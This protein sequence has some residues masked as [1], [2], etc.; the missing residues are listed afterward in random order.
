[1]AAVGGMRKIKSSSGNKLQIPR[2]EVRR[3]SSLQ[4]VH[5]PG[6]PIDENKLSE[7]SAISASSSFFSL[8]SADNSA[9]SFQSAMVRYRCCFGSCRLRVGACAI[10]VVGM[11]ISILAL[12]TMLSLSAEM[13]EE[14]QTQLTAPV[15][16]ALL[17]FASAMLL[18]IGVLIG[19]HFLLAPFILTC[20]ASLFA[21]VLA[22]AWAVV[23]RHSLPPSVLPMVLLTATGIGLLYLWFLAIITMTFVLIRDRKRMGYG[24]ESDIENRNFERASSSIV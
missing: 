19:C 10:G 24:D 5:P 23:R 2:I 1:M 16:L 14:M 7:V 17:Q 8:Y 15:V 22:S 21:C 20:G 11:G 3:S 12:C 4:I 13:S 6:P 9:L 18:I